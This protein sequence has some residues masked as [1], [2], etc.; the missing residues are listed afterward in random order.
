[1]CSAIR[2]VLVFLAVFSA[3]DSAR[4]Q[5]PMAAIHAGR[6]SEA[7]AA[8]AASPDPIAGK[9]VTYYRLLTQGMASA[10]EI[11]AFMQDNPD[12]PAQAQLDRRRQEAL[13]SQPD[14][15]AALAECTRSPLSLTAALLRCA[16]VLAAAGRQT[17]AAEAARHA[18]ITGITDPAGETAFLQR[19]GTA[20]GPDDQRAR[21]DQLA[22]TNSPALQRQLDR[23]DPA[24]R[25]LGAARLAVR[26]DAPAAA[27]LVAALPEAQEGDPGLVLD[28]VRA[29]RRA[30]QD[31]VALALWR[32]RGEAAERAAPAAHR[33]DFWNERQLLAR[34]LL[35]A[36][37]PA[38]AYALVSTHAQVAA[39]QSTDAEFLAGFIALRQLNDPAA[40]ARHFRTLAT[41]SHAVIT[42]GRAHYWLGRAEA[43]AGH[44]P[45]PEY[46]QA[47]EWPTSF[48]GQLAILALGEDQAGIARRIAAQ[49]DPAWTEQ[50]LRYL[51]AREL[52]RAAAMLVSWGEPRRAH[53]F[54]LR[55]DEL[56]PDASERS[57]IARFATGL[58]MPDMAVFVARRMGRDGVALPEAGWPLP[59]DPPAGQIDPPIALGLIRQESSFDAGVISS[60]GARGLMQLMP[61]TAQLVARRIGEATT[62]VALTSDPAQNMRLGTAY[63]RAMLDRFANSLPLAVAAYNAGPNRVDAWLGDNGDPRGGGDPSTRPVDMIDWI[64]LI[65][66]SETRNYVQR[67]LENVVLYRARMGETTPTLLAEWTH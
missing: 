40:A 62:P 36:G 41:L 52:P 67:V 32:E 65:P 9:L 64:E 13:A 34:R 24:S 46:T 26:R 1:M 7:Q 2:I 45:R 16:D 50:Q 58:G 48:Y 22:W 39:E 57:L 18:W 15:G 28:E 63:L 56:A 29:L 43:A 59:V 37:D 14:D 38:G 42:Q 55:L 17:A 11:G 19:W 4:A 60:A 31:A 33:A 53:G 12:W 21:F 51:A 20:I 5:N 44:D 54:I 8:A 61:A 3:M 30:G 6:W 35:R 27:E 10:A 25:T 47:A 66:F 49:H 23:L